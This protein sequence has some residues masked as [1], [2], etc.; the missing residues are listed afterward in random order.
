MAQGA[1]STVYCP[2]CGMPN[3]SGY[4]FCSNCGRPSAPSSITMPQH[5]PFETGTAGSF[6]DFNEKRIANTQKGFLLLIVGFVLQ[7][8]PIVQYIAFII[9][10]VGAILVILGREAFGDRHSTFVVVAVLLYIVGFLAEAGLAVSFADSLAGAFSSGVTS[11]TAAFVESEFAT[12]L[13]GSLAVSIILALSTLILPYTLESDT[14]RALLWATLA[15][16]IVIS[17][18]VIVVIGPEVSHAVSAA[19]ASSPPNLKPLVNLE[20]SL[21]TLRL[22]GE[23]PSFMLA[24]AYYIVWKRIAEGEIPSPLHLPAS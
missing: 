22:P 20:G 15:V 13:W 10:L 6:S 21:N 14:G 19:L 3:T 18:V 24:G 9:S 2:F 7:W 4:P 12:L 23:I 16:Q 1:G 11:N 8:I 5:N 17:L